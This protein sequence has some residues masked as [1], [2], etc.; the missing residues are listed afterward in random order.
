MFFWATWDFALLQG[1][2]D[3]AHHWGYWQDWLGI[4]NEDNPAGN[5]VDNEWY[6]EILICAL[7]IGA[8]VAVKRLLVGLML[9]RQTFVHY[10]EELAKVMKNMV[11]VGEVATLARQIELCKDEFY[12]NVSSHLSVSSNI[13]AIVTQQDDEDAEAAGAP[14][15]C[16][17]DAANAF[18]AKQE[19]DK[20]IDQNALNTTIDSARSDDHTVAADPE[21][22]ESQQIQ[23][24]EL[25]DAW[26]EPSTVEEQEVATTMVY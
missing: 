24:S 20:N 18:M 22:T 8:A 15:V 2:K 23:I 26:E 14:V 7:I 5:V 1:D 6:R 9:G 13:Q 4:F 19:A 12:D 10:G 17:A 25:L 16:A 11:L 3:Y 21:F